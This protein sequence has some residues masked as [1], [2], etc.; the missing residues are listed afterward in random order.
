LDDLPGFLREQQPSQQA[1]PVDLPQEGLSLDD[2]EK[3]LI[4]RALEKHGGNQTKTARFLGMSRR[5]LVY[6]LEKYG[7]HSRTPKVRKQGAVG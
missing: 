5:T 2:V 7:V 1:F 6:R 4:L 3:Q